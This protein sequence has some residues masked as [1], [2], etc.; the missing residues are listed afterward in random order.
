M[1]NKALLFFSFLLI[2]FCDAYA[3]HIAGGELYYTYMGRGSTNNSSVYQITLRLFRE[4]NPPPN[5]GGGTPAEMPP[6]VIIGIFTRAG[7]F[8]RSV[9]VNRND[10]QIIN[11]GPQACISNPPTVCYQVGYYTTTEDLQDNSD[12]YIASYQTCCR[13]T[14]IINI[15]YPPLPNGNPG[16]GATYTCNIP[17][18]NDVAPPEFN[19]SPVFSL[20]DTTLVC[21]NNP[22]T[23]DFSANDDDGDSLTYEFCAAFDRGVSTSAQ[24]ITP[25]SPPYNV[26]GYSGGFSGSLP[27]GTSATINRQT[28]II[29]GIAPQSGSY[30]VNVCI[31]EWRRGKIISQHRKDFTLK[32]SPCDIL[33]SRP[34]IDFT[35]CDGFTINF[36]NSSTG[37]I[38]NYYWN[39]GDPSTTLDT[40]IEVTPAYTFPDTGRY[41]VQLIVNRGLLCTDTGYSVIG[42]YPG[43]FPDFNFTATCKNF[44]TQFND[45]TTTRYG[46]VNYWRW[47]FGN[48]NATND[49]SRLRNPAY[50]YALPDNYNVQLIVG[51]SKGCIDTIQRIVPV[52]DKPPLTVTND[53]LICDIDT[54]QLNAVGLGNFTWSPNYNIN[55]VNTQNPLV[56]P[57]V[58]TKYYVDLNAGPGCTNRDSV[59]VDVK[60][61]V[62]LSVPNDT[63]I[64]RGDAITLRPASDALNYQW[65]PPGTLNDPGVKNPIATPLVN[66]TYTVI[67]NI[68]KCQAQGSFDVS[69]VPYP[70]V[71]AGIDAAICFG[72]NIQL[73]GTTDGSSFKWSPASSLSNSNILNPIATPKIPTNYVLTVTDTLGCPKAVRD[74][75]LVFVVPPV[76]AFAGN[77]TAVVIG[78]P[79]Q[80]LA[81]GGQVY[82]WSPPTGLNKT[83]VADPVANLLSNQTYI[84]RVSTPEGCFAFDTI[85]IKVFTTPPGLFV[86]NAFTPNIDKRNDVFKPIA[87]GISKLEYFKVYNRWGQL[88][89]S[90]GKLGEGW[91][92]KLNGRE[93]PLGVYVWVAKATIYTGAPITQKG[94]V[95][96]IR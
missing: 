29:S 83:D 72:D 18:S 73:D 51:N 84:V 67:G 74:T 41:R 89:Y 33:K 19:S 92:G 17:G 88:V 47:D 75:V 61:F 69:V 34:P 76:Q 13:T 7:G 32:V 10:F 25:S 52:L 9:T 90:T 49:T 62:T 44:P 57:D 42:V 91:D 63:T 68:G 79:L 30:V 80:L 71:D 60:S 37:D 87:V 38:Q 96:L 40:S 94:T 82:A 65:L 4:C 78:Q 77:D 26:I 23:L 59:I 24:N 64:C 28:G 50:T 5:P 27:L 56:S 21:S 1:K 20:K 58:R 85:S 45:A 14:N 6:S 46:V 3:G 86:P 2:L 35:T 53:T 15:T 39:F 54:L 36:S 16:E 93:Q 11:L 43:F 8:V 12:G 70:V 81:T 55:N 48:T 66:T 95:T 22:F 31:T